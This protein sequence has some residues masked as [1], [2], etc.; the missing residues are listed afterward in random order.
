MIFISGVVDKPLLVVLA[1][2][3]NFPSRTSR[4]F[5]MDERNIIP[6]CMIEDMSD[7]MIEIY[8]EQSRQEQNEDEEYREWERV[9]TER[10]WEEYYNAVSDR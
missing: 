1:S 4:T 9:W 3:Q 7:A 5:E 10:Y 6:P 2:N 8:L